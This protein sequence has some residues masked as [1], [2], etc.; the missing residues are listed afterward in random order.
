M[1]VGSKVTLTAHVLC[2]ARLAP[3]VLVCAK[4]PVTNIPVNFTATPLWLVTFKV[5]A[6]LVVPSL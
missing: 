1:A 5:L 3:Q 6:E 4:S 2:A